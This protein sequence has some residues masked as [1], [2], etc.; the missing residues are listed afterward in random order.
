M[1][2]GVSVTTDTVTA[3]PSRAKTTRKRL[4]PS[5]AQRHG[6]LTATA[7]VPRSAQK[8]TPMKAVRED[9]QHDVSMLSE[10]ED[11][12]QLLQQ[13]L[14][15][16]HKTQRTKHEACQELVSAHPTII[17]GILPPPP[18]DAAVPKSA[19]VGWMV[20]LAPAAVAVAP[21]V[22]PQAAA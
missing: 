14:S 21:P 11:N 4:L 6:T 2:D 8:G 22:V 13:Q 12:E 5:S 7:A 18:A 19:I 10:E 20:Q 3:T 17:A 16:P 15:S 1:M 9:K